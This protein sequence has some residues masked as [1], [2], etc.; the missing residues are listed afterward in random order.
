MTAD[1]YYTEPLQRG[2]KMLNQRL[3]AEHCMTEAELKTLWNELRSAGN[4][5]GGNTFEES[6]ASCNNNLK[7]AGLEIVGISMLDAS[8]LRDENNDINSPGQLPSSSSSNQ[9]SKRK[10]KKTLVRYYS[11]I[12]QY[13]DDIAKKCFESMFQPQQQA[14][15]RYVLEKLVELGPTSRTTILNYKN[16]VNQSYQNSNRTTT[17]NM[18]LSQMTQNTANDIDDDGNDN[19][20]NRVSTKGKISPLTLPMVED[21]LDQLIEAKWLI[22]V[23]N[24]H[25]SSGGGDKRPNSNGRRTSSSSNIL[26]DIGPRSYLEISYLLVDEFGMEKDALPQCF[27]HRI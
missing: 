16:D 13:A 14:Y 19:D 7:L 18:P 12:N 25:E 1:D 11:I 27:Y 4:D 20:G 3:L 9:S 21:T 6:I 8:Q 2:Q 15:V 5:M 22:L 17:G 10:P 24:D 26:I 23:T